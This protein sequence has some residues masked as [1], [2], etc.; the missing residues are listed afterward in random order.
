MQIFCPESGMFK[1]EHIQY[2][3]ILTYIDWE[4]LNE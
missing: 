4:K 3:K 1:T 2:I